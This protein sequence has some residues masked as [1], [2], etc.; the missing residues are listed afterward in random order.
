MKIQLPD[1]FDLTHAERYSLTIA[2][3]EQQYAFALHDPSDSSVSFYYALPNSSESKAFADFQDF[4]FENEFLTLPF[5]QVSLINYTAVFTCVPSL[6]FEEKDKETYMQFLFSEIKGK[7]LSHPLP[8]QELTILHEIPEDVYAFFQRSF[9]Q[10][11]IV[12]HTA[13]LLNYFQQ[14][15]PV[16]DCNR[17]IAYRKN[18]GLDILC[19]SPEKL[20]LVNHFDCSDEQDAV[21]YILF[22]WKQLKFNPRNDYAIMAGETEAWPAIETILSKY[23]QQVTRIDLSE[24]TLFNAFEIY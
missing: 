20:L 19:F 24:E 7:I 10:A 21:Y 11:Q 18:K 22:L 4:F 2:I 15:E 17:L 12:H 14:K 13:P 3:H 23:L 9:V 5:K 1:T 6:I 16:T 8:S